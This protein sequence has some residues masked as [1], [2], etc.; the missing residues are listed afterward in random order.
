MPDARRMFEPGQ[1]ATPVPVRQDAGPE[2]VL[3]Y[4]TQKRKQAPQT[5]AVQA[6]R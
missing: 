6:R 5:D 3:Q 1:W 2:R 4:A